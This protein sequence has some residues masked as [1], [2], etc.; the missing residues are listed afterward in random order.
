MS[1]PALYCMDCRR[2]AE[3]AFAQ[4]GLSLHEHDENFRLRLVF[5]HRSSRDGEPRSPPRIETL[6][7]LQNPDNS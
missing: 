5:H 7:L 3:P 1:E 6:P 4:H 2:L